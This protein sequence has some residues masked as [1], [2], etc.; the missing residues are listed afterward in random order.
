MKLARQKAA[1]SSVREK[2]LRAAIDLFTTRGYAATSVREIVEAAGVTKP[3]LY[4]HFTSKEGIYLAILQDIQ[5]LVEEVV[6]V[7]QTASGTVR[8]RIEKFLLGVFDL[9][10]KNKG[11]VRF[12]NAAFWGPAQGAPPFDFDCMHHQFMNLVTD[13]V[14]EGIACGELRRSADPDQAAFVFLGV[15]SFSMDLTLAHPE[16]DRGK[17][18]LQRALDLI[19][20]GVAAPT[21]NHPETVR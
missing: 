10:E 14:K 12:L 8:S 9:F 1:E 5:K 6:A 21:P 13:L 19:F 17:A 4:Y 16:L 11:G 3:A 2:L 20:K 18:G 15:L 7:P